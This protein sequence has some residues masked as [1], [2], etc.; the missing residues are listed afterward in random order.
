MGDPGPGEMTTASGSTRSSSSR[1][2]SLR[3]T[4]GSTPSA[5]ESLREVVNEGIEVIYEE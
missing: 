4:T 3:I 5:A 1:L 2:E